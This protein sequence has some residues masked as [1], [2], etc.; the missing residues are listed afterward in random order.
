MKKRRSKNTTIA[1]PTRRRQH[2]LEEDADRFFN[3]FQTVE[4]PDW[5][6]GAD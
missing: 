2:R 1:P 4:N 5:L 3:P 6:V